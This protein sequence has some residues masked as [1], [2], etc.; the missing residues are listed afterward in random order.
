VNADRGTWVARTDLARKLTSTDYLRAYYAYPESV[1]HPNE[2]HRS[3]YNPK[4][5]ARTLVAYGF[6]NVS[7]I[8]ATVPIGSSPVTLSSPYTKRP[9]TVKFTD[10]STPLEC[11]INVNDQ[12]GLHNSRLLR[13]RC[14]PRIH[15]LP[16]HFHI[17]GLPR[18]HTDREATRNGAQALGGVQELERPVGIFRADD[19]LVL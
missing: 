1:V 11:D 9:M 5:L 17:S 6:L 7:P 2:A 14:L 19:A 15:F 8:H 3:I 18:P 16:P 4:N 10:H 12:F 13:A